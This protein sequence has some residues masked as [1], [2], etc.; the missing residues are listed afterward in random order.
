[1]VREAAEAFTVRGVRVVKARIAR[2]DCVE[3]AVE[4]RGFDAHFAHEVLGEVLAEGRGVV[5]TW[6]R[7]E[8]V[9]DQD[10]YGVFAMHYDMLPLQERA[11]GGEE[12]A[13]WGTDAAV[14]RGSLEVRS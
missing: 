14:M 8:M 10:G 6:V 5:W 3:R 4:E 12:N 1:M 13:I 9:V 2:F 7:K 11:A